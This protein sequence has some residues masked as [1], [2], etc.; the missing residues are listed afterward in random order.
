M[1]VDCASSSC[2]VFSGY[3]I[4]W[5]ENQVLTWNDDFTGDHMFTSRSA[6]RLTCFCKSVSCWFW[7]SNLSF[8][9]CVHFIRSFR[10]EMFLSGVPCQKEVIGYF[11]INCSVFIERQFCSSLPWSCL[12]QSCLGFPPGWLVF[13]LAVP[14]PAPPWWLYLC[15]HGPESPALS[16]EPANRPADET[17][18]GP[19]DPS[20]LTENYSVIILVN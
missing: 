7:F 15:S 17:P 2:V 10:L 12:G 8:C 9:S 16:S 1:R 19:S 18:R 6:L 3:T 4:F 11:Q 5:N 14:P 13:S 20:T